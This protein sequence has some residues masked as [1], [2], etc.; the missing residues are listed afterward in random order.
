VRIH[1]DRDL[2]EA[3]GLCEQLA[4]AVFRLD[5][6]DELELLQPSPAPEHEADARLAA[7]R[8]PRAALL[9]ED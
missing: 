2:C 9:V 7:E 1:V 8:C 4:P 5:D 3:N 6:D